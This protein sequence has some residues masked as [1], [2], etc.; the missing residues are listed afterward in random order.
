MY[1]F[2]Q[3]IFVKCGLDILYTIT[4]LSKINIIYETHTQGYLNLKNYTLFISLDICLKNPYL[5]PNMFWHL[6]EK[7]VSMI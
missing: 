1:N 4:Y 5:K 3:N 6:G 7:K 2:N